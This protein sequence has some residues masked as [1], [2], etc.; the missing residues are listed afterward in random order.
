MIDSKELIIGNWL[1]SAK[2]DEPFKVTEIREDDI[3]T[4]NPIPISPEVLEKCEGFKKYQWQDAYFI[5]TDFGDL[6]IQFYMCE[7]I[8]R[9]VKVSTDSQGQK[10]FS[11]P[12]IGNKK[13][14][15]DIVY[16]H[17]LQNF[18]YFLTGKE[19]NFKP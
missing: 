10:M 14:R 2:T 9:M 5:K 8:T 3:I 15:V 13:S 12:L 11:L 19:I 16:L 17:Q 4:A 18:T 1:I 7:I 6:Y